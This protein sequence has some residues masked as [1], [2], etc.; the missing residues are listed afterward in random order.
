MKRLLLLFILPIMISCENKK[1]QDDKDLKTDLQV[2][3]EEF[4]KNKIDLTLNAIP[5]YFSAQTVG[6]KPFNSEDY[7]G[8]DLVIFIYD[9]SY[10]KKS[11]TYDM[12]AELNE[13]YNSHK[14]KVRF[15][16]II[17]GFVD[18]DAELQD[19][20]KSSKLEFDQI[21]NTVSTDKEEKLI[22]NISCTPAKILI[23]K[24]GKVIASSCG[25]KSSVELL[26]KLEKL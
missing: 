18:N 10:L 23:D 5:K 1:T 17:E 20:I 16:G 7:K 19:Y 22:H 2:M 9:K 12:A 26:S 6:G 25:G 24:T 8:K 13:I 14:D 4:N 21:D 15:I 11:D 3:S